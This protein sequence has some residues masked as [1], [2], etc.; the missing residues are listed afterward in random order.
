MLML[1]AFIVALALLIVIH[2][3]G[4]YQVA[5]WCGVK[6]LRFSI[7]FGKP[8]FARRLGQ[9]QTE[10][11]VAAIPMGGY[12]KMLDERELD[13]D[14]LAQHAQQLHRAFNRQSV[15]KRIAIVAAG[16]IANLLLAIV[17]Y[18]GLISQGVTGFAANIA[19]PAPNTPAQIAG[20]QGGQKIIK[21]A[22]KTI[23]SWQDFQWQLLQRLPSQQAIAIQVQ[24]NDQS[25]QLLQLDASSLSAEQL[26]ENLMQHLGFNLLQP[27]IAAVIGVIQ[28]G[29]VAQKVGLQV[30]D[31]ILALNGHAID[32]WGQ[33]V[34]RVHAMPGQTVKLQVQRAGRSLDLTATLQAVNEH[35]VA[36]GKLG[37]GPLVDEASMNTMLVTKQL[38]VVAAL[39]EAMKKTWQTSIFS[40][41][42]LFKMITGQASLKTISGPVTI[43]NYAGQSAHMGLKPYIAFLAILSIS[44]GV[45]NLLPIPILDGGHLMYYTA[46]VIR[47]RPLSDAWMVVGQKVGFVILGALMVIAL[48]NDFSR[49]ITGSY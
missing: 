18:W 41:K 26:D 34:E 3:F 17:L 44:L 37:L 4:H 38:G 23:D 47:G 13:A 49:L 48:F 24:Q 25:T 8:L 33:L 20:F 35:G 5:K 21:V 36:T 30:N 15:Y 16:P 46:E 9:D 19:Q 2:E 6:V 42:M 22:D 11:M 43:A 10:F 1:L 28:E 29:S 14:E 7:G 32:S 12:V 27:Q 45:L 31:K 39:Q 40:L